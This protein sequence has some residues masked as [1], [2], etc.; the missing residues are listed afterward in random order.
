MFVAV[1]SSILAACNST[2][3]PDP[4]TSPIASVAAPIKEP[5]A[6]PTASV[7]L[8]R[9]A[10]GA[11]INASIEKVDLDELLKNSAK[12]ADRTVRTEGK[13]SAVCQGKGCWLEL[14]DEHG[15]AHVK[16]GNH[17]FFVPRSSSGKRAIV[18]ARVLPAVDTGHCEQEAVEQTGQVARIEL[19]A[20]GVE[21]F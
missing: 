13:V 4:A 6:A 8:E 7:A 1:I 20:T 14:A 2:A 3:T 17:K 19:D 9:K 18:E 15:Q 12:Y 11:P 21:L 5:A 10:F 16:L